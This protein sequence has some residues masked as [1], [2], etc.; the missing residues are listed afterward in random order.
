MTLKLLVSPAARIGA[1]ALSLIA[2]AIL[3]GCGGGGGS[4]T[5]TGGTGGG[6]GGGVAA[7]TSLSGTVAAG[8]PMLNATV[9]VKG[10]NGVSQTA[11]A[12]ADGSYSGL[13]LDGLTAPFRI[14]A[15][16]LVD[17]NYICYYSV[18]NSAG[19]A[20]VT[21]LTHASV[22]LALGADAAAMFD[23]GGVAPD[24]A[25]LDAK[26]LL[27]KE[28]LAAIL[29]G[30]SLDT[31]SLDFATSAFAANRT[32]MDK[33]LDA[34]KITTGSD[35]VQVE[36]KIGAGN[37]YLGTDGTASGA[38]TADSGLSVDLQGISSVFASMS[39]AIGAAS[40]S[41]CTAQ[42][43][44]A[45]IFDAAFNLRIDG[46]APITA[47]TASA[48]ICQLANQGSLLGGVIASP[49][50]RDCDFAAADKICTVGFD[51]VKDDVVFDGAEL[52]VVLRAGA[53]TW[54]LLGTESAYEIHVNAA[55]QRTLRVDI[56]SATPDYLRALSFDVGNGGGTA[57][58]AKVYQRD[59]AGT[60]W[61]SVPLVVL[62]EG[63]AACASS[64]SPRLTIQGGSCGSSWL[65]LQG[66]GLSGD[67]LIDAF[68]KRGRQVRIDLFAEPS[69]TT[70]LASVVKRVEGVPPKLAALGNLP[71]L[72]L[73]ASTKAAL[74]SYDGSGAT[75]TASWQVNK[76]V[77]GKD[78]TFCL[79]ADCSGTNRVAHADVS[80]ARS[81]VNQKT[82][83]LDLA[84]ASA[85]A[86]KQLSLY[87]RDR[88]Q[89]GVSS[90]YIS[91]GGPSVAVCP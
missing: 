29:A 18:V 80:S 47:S 28:K 84:P 51:I 3:A 71:W 60:G 56:D 75:F 61:D 76:A 12:G 58:L 87:G 23:A 90:N 43:A 48:A 44:A 91:C 34:V 81:G 59:E 85:A 5:A 73:D 77:S 36:G 67:A 83:A 78:I 13:S 70:L 88:E 68:Y 20:N 9:S 65:S 74:A 69:G 45:G 86:Y 15:C 10:A 8:S 57:R 27:L 39:A 6:A 46:G 35:F 25:A 33:L 42:M 14:Q 19:T 54:K 50:L 7:P 82:L 63:D 11:T 37:V 64:G 62:D 32:G 16:G 4:S 49:L 22:S 52:A 55:V 26:Q 31:R 24:L 2:S 41:A 66:N 89:M 1:C 30:V 40:E 21:P 79:A 53:P 72:E 17:G 38:I